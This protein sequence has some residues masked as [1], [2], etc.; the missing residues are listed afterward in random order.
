MSNSFTQS[1][2]A[3]ILIEN[4]IVLDIPDEVS[5][6]GIAIGYEELSYSSIVK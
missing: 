5:R 3:N 1:C 4:K 2:A 6:K